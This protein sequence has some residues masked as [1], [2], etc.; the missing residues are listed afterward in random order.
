MAVAGNKADLAVVAPGEDAVAV[1]FDLADPVV[2]FGR[3]VGHGAKLGRLGGRELAASGARG[4]GIV[5]RCTGL[6]HFAV[7]SELRRVGGLWLGWGRGLFD[8]VGFR[9]CSLYSS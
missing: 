4:G 2:A 5:G 3:I 9:A 7:F 6:F 8:R 1:E